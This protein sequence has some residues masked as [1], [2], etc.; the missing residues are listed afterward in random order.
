MAKI[1]TINDS[2]YPLTKPT[3]RYTLQNR[4]QVDQAIN[5]PCDKPIFQCLFVHAVS[6]VIN[7]NIEE[8]D[9]FFNL[10][11]CLTLYSRTYFYGP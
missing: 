11:S 3:N 1:R 4:S 2:L 6:T 8:H 9:M 5:I 7:Y 10:Y